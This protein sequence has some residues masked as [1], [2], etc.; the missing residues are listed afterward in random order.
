MRE[1]SPE[2]NGRFQCPRPF[3]RTCEAPGLLEDTL[4]DT[5][6]EDPGET[7]RSVKAGQ[8]VGGQEGSVGT[9]IAAEAGQ[10]GPAA[11]QQRLA[12]ESL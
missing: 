12:A 8:V 7:K 3:L 1:L 9:Q 10:L 6:V 11:V 2:L 5:S 4:E